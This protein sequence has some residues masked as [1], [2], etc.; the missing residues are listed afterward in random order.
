MY[1]P[2]LLWYVRS[3]LLT[4]LLIFLVSGCG[5]EKSTSPAPHPSL[6]MSLECTGAFT[7]LTVI[8]SGG[9]MAE[10]SRFVAAFADGHSDTLMLQL[11]KGNTTVCHLSNIRG[12]VTVTNDQ[13][14]LEASAGECL[15][16]Y[17]QS[18]LAFFD[19][20][21]IIPSPFAQVNGTGCTWNIYL[22]NLTSDPA[23]VELLR[24]DAGLTLRCVYANVTGDL[25]L[26]GS[27]VLCPDTYGDMAIASVVIE[28][29]FDISSG[30]NPQV[31][32]G[33]A[34][35]TVDG[36][37]V[38]LQGV[39]GAIFELII[40]LIQ[41]TLT[42]TIEDGISA[43]INASIGPNI[44]YLVIVNTFCGPLPGGIIPNGSQ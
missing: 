21:S 25:E 32:V 29:D 19:L 44:G 40:G 20:N 12:E 35:T 22:T 43:A 15:L 3:V 30:D 11:G 7:D 26:T 42:Q 14:D 24:T 23:A 37:Q 36:F 9:A 1:R 17:F 16:G 5:D 31:T 41:G 39:I 28:V 2:C 10:P 27:N 18:A 6:S 13:W 4:L 33:D 8:N 38:N 34:R